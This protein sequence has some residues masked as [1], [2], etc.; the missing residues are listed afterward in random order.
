MAKR[1]GPRLTYAGHTR[2]AAMLSERYNPNEEVRPR[3]PSYIHAALEALE[4]VP[5]GDWRSVRV[6]V[7]LLKRLGHVDAAQWIASNPRVWLRA[8][9]IGVADA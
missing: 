7:P 5:C 2:N 3:V 4:D 6:V 9:Y 1:K 8:A